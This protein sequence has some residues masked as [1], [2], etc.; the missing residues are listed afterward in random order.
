MSTPLVSIIIDNYNYACFINEAIESACDQSYR[1]IEIIVVDDGSTDNSRDVILEYSDRVR[2]I[3]KD[4]GGQASA[5]NAGFMA[6]KGDIIIFLDSDDVLLPDA[7]EKVVSVFD[8]SW[9]AKVH[10]QLFRIDEDGKDLN[11]LLPKE[12]LAEGNLRDLVVELGPAHC[13]GP[14]NSPPTSGNA[15][16]RRFIEDIFPMPE[17]EFIQTADLYLMVLAP[18]FGNIKA[19]REPLGLYRVHGKNSTLKPEYLQRYLQCFEHCCDSLSRYL[20]KKGIDVKP[21]YWPRDHWFHLV[22]ETIKD[23]QEIIPP[24]ATFILVDGNDLVSG[25]F[26]SGRRRIRFIERNGEY[27][28]APAN[29]EQAIEEVISLKNGGATAIVFTWT[30]FWQLN[31]YKK[32]AAYLKLNATCIINNSRLI[33]FAL[34]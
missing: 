25:E 30:N 18:V 29:D 2:L 6:S 32:L 23:I 31:Y 19:L 10:W 26:I 5:F 15:W 24:S 16:S 28:G 3:L 21:E 7:V 13:G 22:N 33:G 20:H 27:Y 11:E 1:N 8:P 17:Q 12:S 34:N 14:P 9:D 4:N